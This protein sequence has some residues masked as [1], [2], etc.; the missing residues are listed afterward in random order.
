MFDSLV[1]YLKDRKAR[2]Q[3]R[4]DARYN[5][6]F[7]TGFMGHCPAQASMYSDCKGRFFSE[8]MEYQLA[9]V[10]AVAQVGE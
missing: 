2:G 3:T 7:I 9:C 4:R 6:L 1:R 10:L 8:P 5:L